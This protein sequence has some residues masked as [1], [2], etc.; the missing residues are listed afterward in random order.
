MR[1]IICGS[2]CFN[3]YVLLR[4]TMDH[5]TSNLDESKLVILSGHARGAD[6][7]GEK[8]CF[9]RLLKYEVYR[10]EYKNSRDKIAPLLR[11]QTMV[12]NADAIVA[13]H[14]GVSTGT[15]DILQRAEK[16]GLKIK[17]IHYEE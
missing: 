8:W 9:Q 4:K 13:F 3:D 14:N 6:L 7:L 17:V 5:L 11:N 12:D 16:K 1:I 2:R 15:A 10:P